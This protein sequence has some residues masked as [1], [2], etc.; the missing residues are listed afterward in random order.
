MH[1]IY[2]LNMVNRTTGRVNGNINKIIA[3]HPAAWSK[4]VAGT[5]FLQADTLPSER[6]FCI[7]NNITTAPTCSGCGGRVTYNKDRKRYNSFCSSSC[8]IT[9]GMRQ[10]IIESTNLERY[11]HACSLSHPAV[12]NKAKQTMM[13]LYGGETSGQSPTIRKKRE[14]TCIKRYGTT[15]PLQRHLS[16][17][18][19]KLLNDREW[20]Y[21]QHHNQHKSQWQLSRELGVSQTTVHRYFVQHS[22]PVT[23]V[24]MS[25]SEHCVVAM[26]TALTDAHIVVGC[27]SIIPPKEIDVLLPSLQV[28]VEVDGVYWHSEQNGKTQL[29]HM[30]KTLEA[31][32]K[33]IRLLH[34]TDTDLTN[35]IKTIQTNLEVLV[36]GYYLS[37]TGQKHT[38]TEIK[39]RLVSRGKYTSFVK[40]HYT[41]PPPPASLY[42]GTFVSGRMCGGVALQ[43]KTNRRWEIVNVACNPRVVGATAGE[44]IS[45]GME[46]F[47]AARNP[48]MVMCFS[49]NGW[50]MESDFD[51]LG[52]RQQCVIPPQNTYFFAGSALSVMERWNVALQDQSRTPYKVW[53][54]GVTK[55]VMTKHTTTGGRCKKS[56]RIRRLFSIK[57]D[58]FSR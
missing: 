10:Q 17:S 34:L 12:R 40:A 53:D 23:A 56:R 27:R 52:M 57:T 44:Q 31:K 33:G 6:L 54:C 47:V 42:I 9:S 20:L 30:Q 45:A 43:R 28:G 36:G 32:E 2:E 11:G 26:L 13:S 58:R 29:Y 49:D 19:L 7:V 38:R 50:G 24:R 14:E 18:A 48:L 25:S 16:P 22:I 1:I 3:A 37:P 46:Y 4:V 55:W 51:C 8:S 41:S 35:N 21:D 39:T 15:N 5:S